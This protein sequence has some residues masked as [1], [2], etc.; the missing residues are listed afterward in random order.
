MDQMAKTHELENKLTKVQTDVSYLK[1]KMDKV[2][3]KLDSM[4]DKTDRLMS[5]LPGVFKDIMEN[6]VSRAEFTSFQ[7]TVLDEIK[8]H[9]V[10][11]KR[12]D[13]LETRNKV[14]TA[15]FSVALFILSFGE[16]ITKW[17]TNLVH[18]P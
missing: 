14:I 7:G 3:I 13:G 6:Y 12:L 16:T 5:E 10:F 9:K 17:L 15:V 2:E 8:E 18:Q 11:D 1:K 4:D